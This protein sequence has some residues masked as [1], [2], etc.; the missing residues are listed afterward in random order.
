MDVRITP[1]A[2]AVDNLLVRQHRAA[3]IAP[4]DGSL[5][6]IRQS[7]LIKKLK[8][9]LCPAVII[10]ATGFHLPRPVVRK[11]HL[12]LLALH[13]FDIIIRPVCRTHP[14]FYSRVLCRHSESVE[15]HRMNNVIPRHPLV[16]RHHVADRI[17]ADMSHVKITRRVREHFQNIILFLP[18]LHFRPVKIFF[19]PFFLPLFF[20]S[21]R[22]VFIHPIL[23][24]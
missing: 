15:A 14:M 5:F 6:F 24:Q 7:A 11:P 12:S 18:G 16:T 19:R 10:G 21:V 20:D 2:L 13:V 22:R 3:S 23:L 4:I 17:I 9:P 8:K 1:P